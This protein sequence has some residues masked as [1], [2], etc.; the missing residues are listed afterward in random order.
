MPSSIG[1]DICHWLN[2]HSLKPRTASGHPC[3][4]DETSSLCSGPLQEVVS[5]AFSTFFHT[6]S[7]RSCCRRKWHQVNISDLSL[8]NRLRTSTPNHLSPCGD[9][10]CISAL[11]I[12]QSL[13]IRYQ[14]IDHRTGTT[15]ATSTCQSN[16]LALCRNLIV[17]YILE[18]QH[19]CHCLRPTCFLGHADTV[20]L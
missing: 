10:S 1:Y 5:M 2:Y 6:Y 13:A 4:C 11:A 20:I 7:Q 3:S 8:S 17:T 14:W 9:P 18:Y 15:R 19:A 12:P 16:S